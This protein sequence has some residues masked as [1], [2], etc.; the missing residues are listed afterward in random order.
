MSQ[1]GE[2]SRLH[3]VWKL[4]GTHGRPSF[5]QSKHH[6]WIE[7]ICFQQ[8]V[9]P[10]VNSPLNCPKSVVGCVTNPSQS[11]RKEK[12]HHAEQTVGLS[13][14]GGSDRM[15]TEGAVVCSITIDHSSPPR[16]S[17]TFAWL[18][19]RQRQFTGHRR[20]SSRP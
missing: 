8:F 13:G 1:K 20:V 7:F 2:K 16:Y 19:V 4:E 10:A 5:L 18:S 11:F 15:L 9:P 14:I 6:P 12:M 17:N 3:N